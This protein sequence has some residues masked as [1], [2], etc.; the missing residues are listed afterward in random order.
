MRRTERSAPPPQALEGRDRKGQTEL[1]R[2]KAYYGS[3]PAPKKVFPFEAYRS[4]DVRQRL[5]A[6]F[7]GKC[8]YCESTYRS[9][10]PMDVEHYRPKGR[11]E[12][13]A[14]H[15]GYWW[16]AA[17]WDNLLPSCIH[18][19]RRSF[20]RVVAVGSSLAALSQVQESGVHV[21][22]CGKQN[23]FPVRNARGGV[24]VVD[25]TGE[26]ALL[27]DPCRDDPDA[28]LVFTV[29]EAGPI[30]LVLP[31]L[32]EE[33]GSAAA[34]S[35][36]GAISIQVYGLNRLGLV[37]ERTRVLRRLE[38][39]SDIVTALDEVIREVADSNPDLAEQ[40]SPRL[41][42]LIDR[43]LFEMQAMGAATEPYSAMVRHWLAAFARA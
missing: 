19:N 29:G 10:A 30:S 38:F 37:Q 27:L 6:L 1:E 5:T 23:A 3:V 26:E 16:L 17:D 39:L 12:G 28:H 8:A 35:A 2:A 9:T 11:P 22:L 7:H 42:L 4:E 21:T 15:P 13:D 32:I 18:C 24:G 20:Q 33:A 34:P 43:V 31:R 14:L 41:E 25:L 40:V 36:R